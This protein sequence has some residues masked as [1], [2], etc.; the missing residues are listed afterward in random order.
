MTE[1]NRGRKS[2][3][4]NFFKS[5]AAVV[6]GNVI[7]LALMPYLP[8]MAQHQAYRLDLGLLVDFWICLVMYGIIELGVQ[9]RRKSLSQIRK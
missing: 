4:E 3:W 1:R 5:L 8:R 9:L 7:F 2:M 6:S